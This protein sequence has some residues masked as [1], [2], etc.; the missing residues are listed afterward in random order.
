M[1]RIV[2][3]KALMNRM[4]AHCKSAYPNEACGLVAGSDGLAE[5]VY[6]ITNIEPTNVSYLMDPSEQFRA[7]KNMRSA[8][9]KMTAIFHS[10][11]YGAPY[12]SPKDIELAFY[13]DSVYIILSLI[14]F[15]RPQFRAFRIMDGK[16][17]EA[18]IEIRE[19]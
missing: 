15:G 11:P 8:G 6:P 13:P 9:K 17:F 3:P 18:E 19:S 7:M 14:D 12:P 1:N 2:V 16:V 10:H 5:V 4:I